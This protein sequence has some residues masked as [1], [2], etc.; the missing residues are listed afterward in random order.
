[1][2]TEKK[3]KGVILMSTITVYNKRSEAEKT[4]RPVMRSLKAICT[5]WKLPM[6]V[7]VAVSNDENGTDY[8][9]EAVVGI[10]SVKSKERL[11]ISRILLY[12]NGFEKKLPDD[13]EAA[14]KVL[15]KYIQDVEN[16]EGNVSVST[17]LTD[18]R[19]PAYT[20]IVGGGDDISFGK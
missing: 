1:M 13:V 11:R 10:A 3:G 12:I 2:L 5:D 8:M 17:N 7:S 19:I 9:N 15:E 20:E 18:D 14:V 6:F 16:A 4:I